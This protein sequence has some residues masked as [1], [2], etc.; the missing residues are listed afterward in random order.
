[1][2]G[3]PLGKFYCCSIDDFLLT[4]FQ[5]LF[6]RRITKGAGVKVLT[7]CCDIDCRILGREVEI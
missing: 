6:V 3:R 4:I 5:G 2:L 7:I 1:M